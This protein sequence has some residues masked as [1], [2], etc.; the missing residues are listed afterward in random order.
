MQSPPGSAL[1]FSTS[2]RRSPRRIVVFA[3]SVDCSD[4]ETTNFGRALMCSPMCEAGPGAVGQY[5]AQTLKVVRPNSSASAPVIW[6][7]LNAP[8]A[9]SSARI[10]QPLRPERC[11]SNPGASMTP[12]RVMNSTTI[13]RMGLSGARGSR[14]WRGDREMRAAHHD[15]ADLDHV[16]ELLD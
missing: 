2:V 16:L 6:R 3:Q 8:S 7:P 9:S 13:R 10:A 1:I 14:R 12:L 11:S 15:L 5:A 4:L